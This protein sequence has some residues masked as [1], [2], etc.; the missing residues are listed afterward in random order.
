LNLSPDE[1]LNIQEKIFKYYL[2]Q[3]VSSKLIR[4]PFRNDRNPTCGFYYN[5]K[6]VLK[7]HDFATNEFY[8]AIDIVKTLF[9]LNYYK[10]VDKI[11]GDYEYIINEEVT[12]LGSKINKEEILWY[13]A[14]P[15]WLNYF[16]KYKVITSK[17]L[18]QYKVFSAKSVETLDYTLAK[19]SK[20][21]PLFV[22]LVDDKIKWY[23]PLSKD[24][25]KK[26]GGTTNYQTFFGLSQLPRTGKLLFI[27]SSLKDV[28]VLRGLGFNAI[29]LNSETYGVGDDRFESP[30]S[31]ELKKRISSLEKRFK[32]IIFY[33]NNDAAGTIAN[34][35]LSVKYRKDYI[36][37]PKG[38]PKD[39]SDFIHKYSVRKTYRMLKKQICHVVSPK[40]FY[41]GSSVLPY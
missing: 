19:G 18:L 3:E 35:K 25:S 22:Y 8:S 30:A 23:K 4:S 29:A 9:N 38:T 21:N 33:M 2:K 7:L 1:L 28:M 16:N 20:T 17:I 12:G 10:A 14:E 24:I 13:P 32:Y 27:T 41:F 6:G 31:K 39:I 37:N 11:I 15:S 40:V 36:Q 5:V 34:I 26:W